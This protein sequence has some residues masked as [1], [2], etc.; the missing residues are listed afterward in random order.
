MS[1]LINPLDYCGCTSTSSD[2]QTH[3]APATDQRPSTRSAFKQVVFTRQALKPLAM[4]ALGRTGADI[5]RMVREARQKARRQKR[6][7]TY[8]D[9]KDALS[10]GQ[11]SMSEELLWRIA[12]HES[13]HALAMIGFDLGTIHTALS[14]EL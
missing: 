13:G 12:L 6:K 10:G 7:L 8:A 14:D 3:N 9:I 5:E 4:L 2:Q 1:K 11:S